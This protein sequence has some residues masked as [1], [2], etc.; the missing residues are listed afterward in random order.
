MQT[1]RER[2]ESVRRP[3]LS[4]RVRR[5]IG[6]GPRLSAPAAHWRTDWRTIPRSPA[7]RQICDCLENRFGLLGPT[8]V[9]IPP[10]PLNQAGLESRPAAAER[11]AVSRTFPASPR[12]STDVYAS[13]V[14]SVV[15]GAR[16]AHDRGR[17]SCLLRQQRGPTNVVGLGP[18]LLVFIIVSFSLLATN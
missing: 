4:T 12:E 13:P 18:A 17:I 2:H 7:N 15:T 9:Q 1:E 10:P 3:C 6:A 5:R 11:F 8:R 16:L 14:A